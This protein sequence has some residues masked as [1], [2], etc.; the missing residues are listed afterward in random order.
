MSSPHEEFETLLTLLMDGALD[1]AQTLR[2]QA[3]LNNEPEL[4]QEYLAQMRMHALLQ[5]SAGKVQGHKMESA[6]KHRTGSLRSGWL[7]AAAAFC[8]LITGGLTW[9][10]LQPEITHGVA[11]EV[12]EVSDP[13]LK[14]AK[15][16]KVALTELKMVSGRL[17]FMLDSG[18]DVEV[19]G[20][21]DVQLL[22]AMHLRVHLGKVT[23]EVGENAKGFVVDTAQTRIVD[24]GTKFGVDVAQAGHTDVVVFQGKVEL[25]DAQLTAKSSPALRQ[26]VEGEAVRVNER[27]QLD[28]ISSVTSGPE[29][30]GEWSTSGEHREGTV[31]MSVFDNLHHPESINYYRILRG[32]MR[33][34]AQAFIAKRHEWNG[35]QQEGMPDW[36]IGADLVQTFGSGKQ[37]TD[38]QLT[39]NVAVPS[40]IYVL[41]DA[42]MS[43]PVW[44]LDR[45]T[46]T[47]ARIGLENAPLPDAGLPVSKGAG[48]GRLAPFAIWKYEMQGAGAITLGPPPQ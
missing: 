22:S 17:R 4:R 18:A 27:Q 42:R 25:F 19:T 21:A 12:L 3:L 44:L 11:I 35:L 30:D 13:T 40:V 48:A 29:G 37:N 5:W 16:D 2:F 39:V 7:V 8:I 15:G 10:L 26:L 23:A 24:L 36:L 47:G 6:I 14:F 28:R 34:D 41:V 33:E 9:K 45:F 43:P 31:I 20:P 32:G 46:D 38:L 1:E